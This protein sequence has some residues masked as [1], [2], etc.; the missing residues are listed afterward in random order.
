MAQLTVHTEIICEN[1]DFYAERGKV[2]PVLK[3]NGYGLGMV[4]LLEVLRDERNVSLFACS[5]PSEAL[6]LAGRGAQILLLSPEYE[7]EVLRGLLEKQVILSVESLS[8]AEQISALQIPAEVHIAVDT[9][10]G[11]FGFLPEQE[12]DIRKVFSLPNLHVCGIF[13]HFADSNQERQ[14]EN[15]FG[16]LEKLKDLPLGIRHLASTH[17]SAREDC[18]LDAVRVGSGLTGMVDGLRHAA[19]FTGKIC[20]VRTMKKGSTVGYS[21]IRLKRDSAVAVI[22]A[23]TGD[24]AFTYRSCGPRTWLRMR[25]QYVLVSGQ[26]APVLGF[27]GL[28][29][30]EIDVTGIDCKP[31]DLAVLSQSP[32]MV[33][34]S[35]PVI[36]TK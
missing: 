14:K 1:Y 15:F 2:I 27:P 35:V 32:V 13:S 16:L 7:P 21:G 29:H 26:Q 10:L 34:G 30:T 3:S 4:K 20:T 33:S 19:E 24:G 11:R 28:T 23:G 9:G 17:S 25:K 36:Y 12:E 6:T 22:E 18:R 8:Q 31:G 5:R